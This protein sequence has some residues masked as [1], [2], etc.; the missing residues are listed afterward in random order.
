M[1]RQEHGTGFGAL[2][3]TTIRFKFMDSKELPVSDINSFLRHE[4][5]GYIYSFSTE[6]P[7]P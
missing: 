3:Q 2:F 4:S 7:T 1:L 6:T 5:P